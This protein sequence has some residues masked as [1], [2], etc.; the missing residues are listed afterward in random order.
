MIGYYVHHHG[1]GHLHR[2]MSIARELND[3]VTGLS[4]LP[5]PAL[6]IG[7]WVQLD[8]DDQADTVSDPEA[9][10]H[11]HWAPERD[12]G[13]SRRAAQL[14]A[15]L[16]SA[17][18]SA[19][20]SDVSV[21][22]ALLARLHGVPVV[23]VALPG[24]RTDAAHELGYGISRAIIGAWPSHAL[25]MLHSDSAHRSLAPVGAISR[26]PVIDTPAPTERKVLV[27]SGA[28]S[29]RSDA[30]PIET[31]QRETPGWEWQVLGTGSWSDE[32]WSRI[33][34]ASVIITHAGQNA[35][36]EV[37]AARRPAIVVPSSRPFDE[38]VTTAGVLGVGPWPVVVRHEMPASGWRGLL[39]EAATLDGMA[40]SS[41]NDGHGA[42]RAARIIES[43][44]QVA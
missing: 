42:E 44:A 37:A 11:L 38:Q 3:Y 6:W 25:G 39:E 7:E 14:S 1:R 13:I 15:W 2:A 8:P 36:A 17:R 24:V 43:A 18:P 9:G 28:G 34:D 41:W 12:H 5:R 23:S 31:A 10:G 4:T 22:A 27:L 26:F 20:V 29:A 30:F 19:F 16:D 21:E 40:W 33:R 32:P 35:L